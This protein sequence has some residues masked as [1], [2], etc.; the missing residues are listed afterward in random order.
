MQ[1]A[2]IN[3]QLFA[4]TKKRSEFRRMGNSSTESFSIRQITGIITDPAGACHFS[5][6]NQ[7]ELDELQEFQWTPLDWLSS[8]LN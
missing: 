8:I 5:R 6:A 1:S 7:R 3:E 4:H 2:S